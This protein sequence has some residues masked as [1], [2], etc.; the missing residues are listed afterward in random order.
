LREGGIQRAI[1]NQENYVV[2]IGSASGEIQAFRSSNREQIERIVAA[3]N[4][5]IIE[6]R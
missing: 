6:R 1:A 4:K 2:R 5:A 3:V